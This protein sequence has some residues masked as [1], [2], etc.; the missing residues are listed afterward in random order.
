[1]AIDPEP[2]VVADE[3]GTARIARSLAARLAPGDVVH[4]EGPLGA[5]KTTFVRHACAALGVPERVTSP[6]FAV[7]NAYHDGAGRPVTHLDLYRSAGVTVEEA[8][9]LDPYLDPAAILFVE[10]PAAGAGTLP[11]P[12]VVVELEHAGGDRRRIAVRRVAG[13]GS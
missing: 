7:A 5:G 2:A 3:E 13:P 4:L 8:A 6:T 11:A 10:W 12:T 1:M 9:D